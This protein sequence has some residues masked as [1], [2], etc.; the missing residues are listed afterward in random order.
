MKNLQIKCTF[1]FRILCRELEDKEDMFKY[2]LKL[3]HSYGFHI[4]SL[5][6]Q[7]PATYLLI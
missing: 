1:E 2:P 3:F 6:Q 4:N 5:G 7:V